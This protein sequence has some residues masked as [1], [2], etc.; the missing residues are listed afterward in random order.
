MLSDFSLITYSFPANN[1]LTILPI[2]DVHLG[3]AEHLT[4][5]WKQF[6]DKI[7]NLPNTYVI[8]GGDMINNATR[9]SVSNIFDETMRPFEQK[10]RMTEMLKPLKDKILCAV[11]GNHEKRSGKDAD[12]D[13]MADIMCKLDLEDKYRENLAIIKIQVGSI[14][15]NGYKNPTY[16][17]A[18]THGSGGGILTGAS[19]NRGE[20]FS[21]IFDGVDCVIMGHNHKPFVTQPEKIK[22]DPFN[23]KVTFKPF[24]LIS[25]S[26][27]L[28]YG[29]YAL[30]KMLLPSSYAAQTICL[31]GSHKD[32]KVTM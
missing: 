19:V 32:I 17:I 30:Q 16:V 2:S 18:V 24:K 9:S 5:E 13:P 20:R 26:S 14:S 1:D 27:W 11:P 10:K 15:G 7:Y 8:L 21:Y 28:A 3:A 25:M 29:G 31:S 23:N 22:V 6:C 4:A 12:D